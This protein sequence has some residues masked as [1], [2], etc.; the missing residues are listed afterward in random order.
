MEAKGK[1]GSK[2]P[3]WE[4]EVMRALAR[5]SAPVNRPTA[6]RVLDGSENRAWLPTCDLTGAWLRGQRQVRAG[7]R[8]V[9]VK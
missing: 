4:E 1:P 6:D 3:G 8:D 2:R 9:R 5:T 7:I